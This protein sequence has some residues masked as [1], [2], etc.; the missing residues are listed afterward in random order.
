MICKRCGKPLVEDAV[1]CQYCGEKVKRACKTCGKE[2]SEDAIFCPYCGSKVCV[3]EVNQKDDTK[4][5]VKQQLLGSSSNEDMYATDLGLGRLRIHSSISNYQKRLYLFK[6]DENEIWSMNEDGSD[7]RKIAQRHE[8]DENSYLGVNYQGIF[9]YGDG[10]FENLTDITRPIYHYNLKGEYV[11]T[12][13]LEKKKQEEISDI[14]IY[15]KYI[16]YSSHKEVTKLDDC[17]AFDTL[18][19]LDLETKQSKI[20][21]QGSHTEILGIFAYEN[22]I[23]FYARFNLSKNG[24]YRI[25]MDNLKVE[26]MTSV[27]CPPNEVINH[28]KK[29]DIDSR[30]YIDDDTQTEIFSFDFVH[31]IMW[32]FLSESEAQNRNIEPRQRHRMIYPRKI[33][34]G[35]AES[36]ISSIQ[37]R[38]LP[39][40]YYHYEN[41]HQNSFLFDG[42][43]LYWAPDYYTFYAVDQEGDLSENWTHSNHGR[44]ET[45]HIAGNVLIGDMCADYYDSIYPIQFETPSAKESISLKN[46]R[47]VI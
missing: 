25:D 28:P 39:K 38:M 31:G 5:V 32:T 37:P 43:H 45:M 30:S 34:I 29:F 19:L 20:V 24:W 1:F 27:K 33:G 41:A 3:A 12:I 26:C 2:I 47:W 9:T 22:Y 42:K 11:D 36:I 10:I 14:C 23:I 40:K 13:Q 4:N 17:Y 21:Y 8:K 44:T 46:I 16:I 35:P 15:K 6:T 18:R 7:C